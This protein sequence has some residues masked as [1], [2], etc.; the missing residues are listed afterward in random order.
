MLHRTINKPKPDTKP[1]NPKVMRFVNHYV[2]HGNASEAMRQAGYTGKWADRMGWYML[3][4][5][6]VKHAIE[7]L[8]VQSVSKGYVLDKLRDIV[9]RTTNETA[10][11]LDMRVAIEGIKT[12]SAI[13]GYNASTKSESI[14]ISGTMDD[15][16]TILGQYAQDE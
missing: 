4:T 3:Q 11:S 6:R 7:Q 1:V 14:A 8:R 10:N 15:L 2:Q 16:R 5:K 12:V 9:Q 13:Q